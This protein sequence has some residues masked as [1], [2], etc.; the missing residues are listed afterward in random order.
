MLTWIDQLPPPAHLTHTR[1]PNCS[2][3]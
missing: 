3:C 1:L 2:I